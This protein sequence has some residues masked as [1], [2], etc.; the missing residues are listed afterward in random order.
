MKGK[1]M[2]RVVFFGTPDFSLPALRALLA[3]HTVLAVVTQPDRPAGRGRQRVQA[4]PVKE[5][6]V[7]HG[8]EVLQ[9]QRLRHARRTQE[10]LRELDADV[11]VLAAYGQI[12]PA[13]VLAIPPHGCIGIHASL[14]PLLRGAAPIAT[15][16]LQGY[17]RTGVTLMLTDPGMDTGPII[18]QAPLDIAPNDTTA[19]LT[20]RLAELGAA[21]LIEKLPAWLNGAITPTPQDD[22][23]ATFAPP[24]SREDALIHWELP[25]MAI[26]RRV[27]AYDPWPGAYTTLHGQ[28][29]KVLAVSVAP[30][31]APDM[32]AGT[33]I[34][35][36]AGLGVVT[37]DGV[38]LLERVQ[39]AGKKPMAATDLA[40]GHRDLVGARLGE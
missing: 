29:L 34:R 12:L 38:L 23:Q 19:T 5:L 39:L 15:A 22:S 2:A 8:V 17:E 35:L 1:Q 40:R 31:T 3:Q 7:A 6:A 27:R 36:P 33:V 4:S 32:P 37:G 14:L 30:D 13:A 11:F 26:E 28:T 21:L 16:I 24:I 10:R 9:P 18:A 20:A 25:A